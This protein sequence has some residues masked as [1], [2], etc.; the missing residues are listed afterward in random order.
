MAQGGAARMI[1]FG[2][3]GVLMFSNFD[4]YSWPA[5]VVKKRKSL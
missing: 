1:G 3:R 2:N 4:G 5:H